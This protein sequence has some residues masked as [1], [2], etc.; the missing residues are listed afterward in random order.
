M[1]FYVFFTFI[2]L[3]LH[4]KIDKIIFVGRRRHPRDGIEDELP[5]HTWMHEMAM[6]VI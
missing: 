3:H 6:D 2:Y 4:S 5:Y 1:V